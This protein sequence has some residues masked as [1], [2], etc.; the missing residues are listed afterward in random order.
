[1]R[2]GACKR[3]DYT[4]GLSIDRRLGIIIWLPRLTLRIDWKLF[5]WREEKKTT[6]KSTG[7]YYLHRYICEW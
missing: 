7:F 6:V 3:E 5:Y 4:F 1:M 2:F